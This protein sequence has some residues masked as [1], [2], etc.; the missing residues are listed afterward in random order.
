MTE[1][2]NQT[3]PP[4]T[5]KGISNMA[6][7]KHTNLTLK[8]GGARGRLFLWRDICDM[9][10]TMSVCNPGCIHELPIFERPGDS[11]RDLF[12]PKRWVGHPQPLE[13]V[14]NHHPKKV[15][16]ME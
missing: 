6:P 4:K 10:R 1:Y 3:P 15:G 5:A 8:Q 16:Q 2:V 12:I 9:S 13:G 14:T 7:T 11:S